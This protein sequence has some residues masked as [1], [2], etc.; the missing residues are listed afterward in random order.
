M[1]SKRSFAQI[2]SSNTVVDLLSDQEDDS[3]D[4]GED[5]KKSASSSTASPAAA[6][7][8]AASPT[9][10]AVSKC[11]K[12][13]RYC[14]VVKSDGHCCSFK[15]SK[16]K[17]DGQPY[18]YALCYLDSVYMAAGMTAFSGAQSSPDMNEDIGGKWLLYPTKEYVD[19]TWSYVVEVLG[20]GH[21]GTQ[22]KVAVNLLPSD[23]GRHLICTYTHDYSDIA[24]VFR[25]LL[26]I[27]KYVGYKVGLL[28]YK[29]NAA[30]HDGIYTGNTKGLVGY[31]VSPKVTDDGCIY[32]V[33]SNVEV[34]GKMKRFIVAMC[35]SESG[36]IIYPALQT[37]EYFTPSQI[38][39]KNGRKKQN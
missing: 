3:D 29:N 13:D 35:E 14:A 34:N 36:R 38:K 10:S 7:P 6:S 16:C 19:S 4:G 12:N 8:A 2:H 37:M 21:L 24:D 22:A 20:N 27:R 33:R 32:L 30:T 39:Q 18:I 28:S 1:S 31:Y 23:N 15:P 17:C 9:A 25:V 11:D 5:I 26:S